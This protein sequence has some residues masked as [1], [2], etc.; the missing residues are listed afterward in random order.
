[1]GPMDS[2]I[3]KAMKRGRA[4]PIQGAKVV[5]VDLDAGLIPIEVED[6]YERVLLVA[7]LEG[8]FLGQVLL[9][10]DGVLTA[11]RQWDAIVREL[12]KVLWR[13]QL[14]RA[15]MRA[16]RGSPSSPPV[17]GP[18]VSVVIS[19][20]DRPDDLRACLAS[21]TRLRTPPHEI[22]VVDNGSR[23]RAT[24]EVTR[25]FPVRYLVE[26][27]PGKSRA[28]NRGIME[29]TGEIIAVTDDD[30]TV[31]PGW[32]DGLG[33]PFD[34]PL[35]MATTG[36]VGPL[37]VETRAQYLF[38]AH[39]GFKR[40]DQRRVFDGASTSPVLIAA[41]VGAGANCFFRRSIFDEIGLFAEDLGPGTPTLSPEDKY[42][43]F[44]VAEAGYR[45][46]F[47]PARIVWHRHRRSHLDLR[48]S[49]FGYTVG[50][51]AYTTRALLS[52]RDLAVLRIWA[53]WPRH[54]LR[55]IKRLARG[56]ERA[57]PLDMIVAEV[58]G[59]AAGPWRLWQSSRK[60]RPIPPLEKS[61]VRRRD[62][63]AS[64]KRPAHLQIG[65]PETPLLS[66]V[67]ASRNRRSRLREVLNALHYQSYPANRFEVVVVLDG[68]TDGSGEMVRGLPV[69]YPLSLV[70]QPHSGLAVS[71]N[72]G[73]RE[74]S[75]PV[76]IFLD[77]DIVPESDFVAEHAQAHQQGGD[78]VALGYYP[79]VLENPTFWGFVLRAWWEDHFRRKAEPAHQW[80][81]VDFVDGNSSLPRSLL[82]SCGGYD[83]DF[84]GRRQDWELGIRLLERGVKWSYHPR[85][86]GR[87]YLDSRFATS[88]R[89]ARQEARDDVL[90][91]TKHPQVKGQLPVVGASGPAIPR[92]ARL[93][94][95]S[96]D[97]AEAVLR[98]G[99]VALDALERLRLRRHWNRL[100]HALLRCSY[101]L[102]LADRLETPERYKEFFAPAMP[103]SLVNKVPVWLDSPS[104][105]EQVPGPGPLE[106]RLGYAG[107]TIAR[108]RALQPAG[109]W[110]WPTVTDRVV[111]Q[112]GDSLREAI[113]FE[114]LAEMLGGR[115]NAGE[116]EASPPVGPD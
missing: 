59:M 46:I 39:G 66:I 33:D 57:I 9:S 102:G 3:R 58:A 103:R 111:D 35:V 13:R 72:R 10:T 19:T 93:V 101:L 112:A 36:Y 51:F 45:I 68:S 23:D 73:A 87:H 108:V 34:D 88:L 99:V 81:F 43:F 16:A 100:A 1:M 89:H 37:H 91:A 7:L 85:A 31:D 80:T 15:F 82:F 86:K 94:Y 79:P 26:P 74:A 110:D 38:E 47:D 75:H 42:A 17:A 25:E 97:A 84:K 14:K 52:H 41:V 11:E 22:L 4:R 95:S 64:V 24:Y 28:L 62:D 104:A 105:L 71:R 49:L 21:L 32:L 40:H 53:W 29:A 60:R 70:D 48:K 96:P 20:K 27:T 115:P 5:R 77:D 83:E 67:I 90:V 18:S 8:R 76:V 30:C 78:H 55:D 63:P 61:Q 106:L 92:A 113:L 54:F 107:H 56:D 69:S 12:G 65:V 6:R 98:S 44:R 116:P 2:V 50:E 114:Q 109:Q